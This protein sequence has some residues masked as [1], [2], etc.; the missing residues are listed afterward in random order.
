MRQRSTGEWIDWLARD[1]TFSPQPYTQLSS[2]L[3]AAGHRVTADDIQVAGRERERN[4]AWRQHHPLYGAWLTTL[5]YGL[6][7]GIGLY[8]FSVLAWVV[9][10]T[11]LGAG[12]LWYSPNARAQGYLWR[13]GASLHRLLPIAELSKQFKD[14][15]D[16][17][18]NRG[19]Y[20]CIYFAVHALAGWA[21]GLFLFAA[22]AGLTQK[23]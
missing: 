12:V 7:Y 18:A 22:M 13:F 8:T 3:A 19:R 6:G 20:Q 2:I 9:G 1:R 4:E 15:F 5:S 10:F 21:L 23:G 14:F 17:P 16:D 11:G